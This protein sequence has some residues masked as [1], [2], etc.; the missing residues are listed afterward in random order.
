MRTMIRSKNP[1]LKN[2]KYYFENDAI[3]INKFKEK[4]EEIYQI[5][6]I[7]NNDLQALHAR[8]QYVQDREPFSTYNNQITLNC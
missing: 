8:I 3:T 5:R 4:F 6:D 7:F 1:Y 2:L